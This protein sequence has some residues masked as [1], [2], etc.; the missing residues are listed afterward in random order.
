MTEPASNCCKLPLKA[1]E[2]DVEEIRG[3][4]AS[5]TVAKETSAD[6]A[7]TAVFFLELSGIFTQK[8]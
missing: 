7:I 4:T 8:E 3:A 1:S 6:A 5:L 2:K